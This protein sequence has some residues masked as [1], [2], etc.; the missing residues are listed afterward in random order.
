V[1]EAA[2]EAELT[3]HLGHEH[4]EVPIAES[5]RNGTRPKGVLTSDRPRPDRAALRIGT[6]RSHR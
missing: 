3:E 5:L 1:L 2:L 4:G 6:G